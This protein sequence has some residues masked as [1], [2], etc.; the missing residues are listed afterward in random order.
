MITPRRTVALLVAGVVA[1]A[2][3]LWVSTRTPRSD[4]PQSGQLLLPGL[5]KSLN[6]VTEVRLIKGDGTRTTLHRQ[7]K[8]WVVVERDYPADSGHVRRLLLDLAAMQSLEDKTREPANYAQLGVEDVSSPKAGGT[9]VELITPQRSTQLIIGKPADGKSGYAR[10]VNDPQSWLVSPLASVDADPR[11]WLD[12]SVMDVPQTRIR[13]VD[14]HPATG[15]AYTMRRN[16]PQQS[17]FDVSN[18]PKGRELLAAGVADAGATAL[19]SLTLDDVSKA[20]PATAASTAG[21]PLRSPT[22][23][24]PAVH[25]PLPSSGAPSAQSSPIPGHANLV[26]TMSTAG[27]AA[28]PAPVEA[29]FTTFDGISIVVAGHQEG[30]RHLIRILSVQSSSP[31]SQ[32]EAQQLARFSPWELEIPGYKYDMMFRP[33]EELLR[34]PEPP[35]AKADAKAGTGSGKSKGRKKAATTASAPAPATTSP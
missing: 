35:P 24:T 11:R 1:I 10:L 13:E 4:A 31:E 18:L 19:T 16:S 7:A 9:R 15:P 21:L 27:G 30:D 25:A 3:A 28:A 26:H 8:D 12:S 5:E 22:A 6:E 20:E 14:V 34:K 29:T 33:L 23:L 17:N 32:A 2:L